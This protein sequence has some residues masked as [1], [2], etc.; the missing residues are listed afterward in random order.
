M[1]AAVDGCRQALWGLFKKVVIADNCAALANQAFSSSD[2]ASATA[3]L[4]GVFLFT[5]QIYC[6]FSGY[7]D[8]ATGVA[9]LFGFS[10]MQNFA[11]P[12]F[13]R[14]I[15][16]F[17][18]RWHISLS[19]WFRDYL[20]IP[21]GG[22]KGSSAA[23]GFRLF[24]VFLLCGLWHG[25]AATFAI[26]GLWHGFFLS[27]ERGVWGSFLETLPAGIARTYTIFVVWLG[28][29]L[30]RSSDLSHAM[31]FFSTLLGMR[32]GSPYG[33]GMAIFYTR[34]FFVPLLSGIF[35]SMPVFR[36]FFPDRPEEQLSEGMR[37][38]IAKFILVAFLFVLSGSYVASETFHPFLYFR[39]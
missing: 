30:F 11:F 37:L 33:H 18:R 21:L 12:Y 19:N 38:Q 32:S 3:L 29:V 35:L 31:D 28:W 5:I 25:A 24:L 34:E 7:S 20:Y 4:A 8:I 10:L 14:D 39:F 36:S 6:D 9:R 2:A 1:P 23:V 13:S 27:L 26:W 22:G 16:E 17:W 15:A